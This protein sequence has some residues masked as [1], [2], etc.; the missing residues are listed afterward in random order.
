MSQLIS[1]ILSILPIP[2]KLTSKEAAMLKKPQTNKPLPRPLG[3]EPL[4]ERLPVS[5]SVLGVAA[6]A[7]FSGYDATVGGTEYRSTATSGGVAM[8]LDVLPDLWLDALTDSVQE[9]KSLDDAISSA[10]ADPFTLTPLTAGT[11]LD[12]TMEDPHRALGDELLLFQISTL[13]PGLNVFERIE[14]VFERITPDQ[15]NAILER[16]LED[17]LKPPSANLTRYGYSPIA[18]DLQDE[19]GD[20]GGG[21]CGCGPGSCCCGTTWSVACVNISEKQG[22]AK[23]IPGPTH[24]G[25]AIFPEKVSPTQGGTL[26]KELLITVSVVNPDPVNAM[27]VTLGYLDVYNWLDSNAGQKFPEGQGD[28]NGLL[29]HG[30]SYIS[31][32]SSVTI[33]AGQLTSA[34]LTVTINYAYAGDNWVFTGKKQ[35][36]STPICSEML[37]VWRTLWVELDVMADAE[38]GIGL[39]RFNPDTK[40]TP[41]ASGDRGDITK[42]KWM[43]GTPESKPTGEPPNFDVRFVPTTP[44]V[45][46][47]PKPDIS[48]LQTAMIK[49]CIDVKEVEQG[50]TGTTNSTWITGD[51]ATPNPN[52]WDI[53][54]PFMK[55]LPGQGLTSTKYADQGI[56][57]QSRDVNIDNPA[58]WCVQGIGAYEHQT[59]KS[60]DD[61]E[62]D[63]IYGTATIGGG[64]FLIFNETIRDKVSTDS[65]VKRTVS[66]FNQLTT[67]HEVLH[68]FGFLDPGEVGYDPNVEGDIMT[69][70]WFNTPTISSSVL[71]LSP[72]QIQK[73]QKTDHPK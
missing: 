21:R 71:T 46:A 49:A 27:T 68:F 40:Y 19:K 60:R 61:V 30:A 59:D 8:N 26:W 57:N 47:M 12:D 2:P 38:E 39:N 18:N 37:T 24:C 17:P 65:N 11:V 3:A 34:E 35:G 15:I 44:G 14:P 53:T 64:F 29:N 36:D 13:D 48:T 6:G 1:F 16:D 69:T 45:P 62:D 5:A 43:D 10:L 66:Q 72:A 25:L 33:P 50:A 70:G 63:A 9:E 28:N 54:T 22:G 41:G 42:N 58:F 4:E 73:I 7:A 31:M 67:F 52:A 56:S 51:G 20:E 55:N 23:I 32:P